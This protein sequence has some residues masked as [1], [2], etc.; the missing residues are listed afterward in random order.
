MIAQTNVNEN[1]A[2]FIDPVPYTDRFFDAT[3]A[4]TSVLF[5]MVLRCH[6]IALRTSSLD[7]TA[8]NS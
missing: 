2:K 1:L 7:R 3:A 4:L 5:P 8:R 6:A